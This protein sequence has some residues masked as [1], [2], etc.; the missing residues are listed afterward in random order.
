[1]SRF[2]ITVDFQLHP[3]AMRELLPLMVEYALENDDGA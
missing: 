3:G 1:M 2:V